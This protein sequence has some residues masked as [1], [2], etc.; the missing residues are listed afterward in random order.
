MKS[1]LV[2]SLSKTWRTCEVMDLSESCKIYGRSGL[3][4]S[5]ILYQLEPLEPATD[6]TVS[7]F[8]PTPVA[9]DGDKGPAKIWNSKS[10]KNADSYGSNQ[11]G[12]AGRT[13]VVRHSLESMAKMGLLPSILNLPTP[14]ASDA[15]NERDSRKRFNREGT[16]DYSEA[17][18]NNPVCQ[19]LFTAL[20]K[21]NLLPTPTARDWKD[22]M[23]EEA[24]LKQMEKRHSPSLGIL[25]SANRLNL[26]TPTTFDSGSPLPPRKKNDSGGQK[27]PLVSVVGG[28]LNPQF[29]EWMMY[30]PQDY[31]LPKE[32]ENNESNSW[33]IL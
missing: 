28:K 6:E 7:G 30:Y 9:S 3:M 23:S 4:Q 25:A 5:G 14:T 18:M 13:G 33:E 24:A 12:G 26:P 10:R 31:T 8:L 27:P 1:G 17:K 19:N 2:T 22:V 16:K 29:V 32:Y 15:W 21:F 11:G 20:T